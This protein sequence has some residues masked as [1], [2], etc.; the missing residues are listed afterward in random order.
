MGKPSVFSRISAGAGLSRRKPPIYQKIFCS[1]DFF[2]LVNRFASGERSMEPVSADDGRGGFATRSPGWLGGAPRGSEPCEWRS[3]LSRRLSQHPA[4]TA[5]PAPGHFCPNGR[6]LSPSPRSGTFAAARLLSHPPPPPERVW[7]RPP[8][9]LNAVRGGFGAPEH[10]RGRL[11][12]QKRVGS[13]PQSRSG[14]EGG[15]GG[16]GEVGRGAPRGGGR[17]GSMPAAHRPPR[18]VRRRGPSR[19]RPSRAAP[20]P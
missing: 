3:A 4:P 17:T 7:G 15:G 2:R 11:P 18:P 20:R 9:H 13:R 16:E 12:A 5:V 19:R 1:S 6:A 10:G 14:G 8:R